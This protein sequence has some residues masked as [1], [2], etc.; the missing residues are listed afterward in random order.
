MHV[1]M[2]HLPDNWISISIG[3]KYAVISIS[4]GVAERAE[5][6]VLLMNMRC[7]R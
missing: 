7:N 6:R 1:D 2:H 3:V 4:I 5:K